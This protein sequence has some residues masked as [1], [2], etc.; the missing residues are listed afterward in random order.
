MSVFGL[1]LLLLIVMAIG[2]GVNGVKEVDLEISVKEWN[3]PFY[4]MGIQFLEYTLEDGSVEQVL[5]LH[6]FFFNFCII[7]YKFSG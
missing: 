2:I 3:S 4:Q 6:F 7:F 1:F 5:S